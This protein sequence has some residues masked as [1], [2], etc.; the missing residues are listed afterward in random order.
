[1]N[2]DLSNMAT[3]WSVIGGLCLLLVILFG[4]IVMVVRASQG[5][6]R[7]TPREVLIVEAE[8]SADE[9]EVPTAEEDDDDDDEPTAPIAPIVTMGSSPHDRHRDL[10]VGNSLI[11]SIDLLESLI[12][13]GSKQ[14]KADVVK[15]LGI[16]QGD[17]FGLLKECSF[18]TYSFDPGTLVT[19]SMR[20]RIVIV[21][22]EAGEGPTKIAETLRCGYLYQDGSDEPVIIRKAEVEI[23]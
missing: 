18:K 15:Q 19:A 4:G 5:S 16:L 12:K 14:S 21:S 6:S 3:L 20:S 13:S 7:K 1:M 10:T 8:P 22:G 2:L 17:F 23:G 9:L 11:K